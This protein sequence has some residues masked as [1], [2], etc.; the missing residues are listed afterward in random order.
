MLW[1]PA[2][3][4][5]RGLAATHGAA[6][7]WIEVVCFDPDLHRR[8]LEGRSRG[9]RALS[10][11]SWEDVQVRRGEY[12]PWADDRLTLDTTRELAINVAAVSH[13]RTGAAT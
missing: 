6:L 5:W 12:A 8:R 7:W 2:R 3:Q 11:P 10:E 13:V 9:D 4:M 1:S